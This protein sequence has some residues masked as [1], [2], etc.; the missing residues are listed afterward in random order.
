LPD[1][2][3]IDDA[4]NIEFY[5]SKFEPLIS[6]LNFNDFNAFLEDQEH[7]FLAGRIKKHQLDK[8]FVE[9]KLPVVLIFYFLAKRKKTVIKNH[10]PT[11]F[12]VLQIIFNDLGL[13]PNWPTR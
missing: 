3:W 13:A 7:V 12:N 10:W 6:T 4:K 1:A 11:D 8:T 9:F 5:L 2:N